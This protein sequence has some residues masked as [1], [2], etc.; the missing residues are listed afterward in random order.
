[1]NEL[2]V[3]AKSEL[4]HDQIQNNEII[5][6]HFPNVDLQTDDDVE[7]EFDTCYYITNKFLRIKLILKPKINDE[8]TTVI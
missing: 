3:A 5:F 1:M 2:I 7:A 6:K 8:S 4:S